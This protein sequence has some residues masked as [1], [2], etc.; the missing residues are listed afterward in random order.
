MHHYPTE[1]DL[2]TVCHTYAI[3]IP[4]PARPG[5]LLHIGEGLLLSPSTNVVAEG[6]SL[7]QISNR[8]TQLGSYNTTPY[9]DH[10]LVRLPNDGGLSI[11]LRPVSSSAIR[12]QTMELIPCNV[13]TPTCTPF[14]CTSHPSVPNYHGLVWDS[15]CPLGATGG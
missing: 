13:I 10:L 5:K 8:K 4:T 1:Q 14:V 12:H 9:T 2:H 6:Q 3:Y 7:D 15:H 11:H